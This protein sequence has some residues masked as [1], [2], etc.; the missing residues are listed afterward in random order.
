MS[1]FITGNYSYYAFI[2]FIQTRKIRT[3]TKIYCRTSALMEINKHD[4]CSKRNL[5]KSDVIAEKNK[6]KIKSATP[7]SYAMNGQTKNKIIHIEIEM[8]EFP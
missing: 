6:K 7:I 3:R 5:H 1:R 2:H 4:L 8:N